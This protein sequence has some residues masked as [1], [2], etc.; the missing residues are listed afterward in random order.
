MGFF[1]QLISIYSKQLDGYQEYSLVLEGGS[2]TA[3]QVDD[4]QC[5]ER[6]GCS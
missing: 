3:E 2:E 6:C 4:S 1:Y 5:Y